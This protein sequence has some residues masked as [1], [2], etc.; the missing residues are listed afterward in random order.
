MVG[1]LAVEGDGVGGELGQ[2]F[3]AAVPA[4]EERG[5]GGGGGGLDVVL[6][7]VKFSLSV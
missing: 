1:Q 6:G 3:G 7:T 2:V 5:G 4:G